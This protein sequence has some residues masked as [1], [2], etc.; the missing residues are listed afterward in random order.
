[1]MV[2]STRGEHNIEPTGLLN[3]W[4]RSSIKPAWLMISLASSKPFWHAT[5]CANHQMAHLKRAMTTPCLAWCHGVARS[6]SKQSCCICGI[7]LEYS[8]R[9]QVTLPATTNDSTKKDT[10]QKAQLNSC[11]LVFN[12]LL[13]LNYNPES[14]TAAR[15]MTMVLLLRHEE[16]KAGMQPNWRWAISTHLRTATVQPHRMLSIC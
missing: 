10:K 2:C 4:Q 3:H 5:T 14:T 11:C 12:R 6:N 15:V 1:M 7:L 9:E 8:G 16:C 13:D